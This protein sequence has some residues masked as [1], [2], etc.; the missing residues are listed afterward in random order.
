VAQKAVGGG[1]LAGTLQFSP[2]VLQAIDFVDNSLGQV[3][4]KLKQKNIYDDTLFIVASKHGQA[5]IDPTKYG[6]VDPTAVTNATGVDI[7]WQTV[8]CHIL[9]TD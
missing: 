8:S 9:C 6:K 5:P 7:L 2:D 3:V 1:Y 4:A